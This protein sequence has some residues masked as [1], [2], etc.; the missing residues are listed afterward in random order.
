MTNAGN[1]G[2]IM[3]WQSPPV[4]RRGLPAGYG[5]V[6]V[7]TGILRQD[8]RGEPGNLVNCPTSK[9]NDNDTVAMAA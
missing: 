5:D 4:P 7:S 2:I 8:Q 3:V 1:P 6:M 9:I